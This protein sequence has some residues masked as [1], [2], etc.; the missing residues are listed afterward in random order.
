M[1]SYRYNSWGKL[2]SMTD[3]T[4]EKIG[5]KNP[6]R[7]REYCWDEET[8]LYYVSSRYYDPEVGR[9]ISADDVDVLEVQDDLYDKNLY[10]YCDN[11][12]INRVDEEG[13]VW[14]LAAV[15]SIGRMLGT[16]ALTISNVA[17]PIAVGIG[18]GIVVGVVIHKGLELHQSKAKARYKNEKDSKSAT[19]A[20][21]TKERAKYPP[22]LRKRYSTRKKAFD[23]AKRAGHKKR[24][25]KEKDKVSGK[26]FHPNVSSNQRITPKMPSSHNHYMYPGRF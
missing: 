13:D 9:F 14:E 17:L 3:T 1:V 22:A 15:G 20:K 26:H 18:I 11:N 10:A 23:A 21:E 12:P 8:G 25:K 24:P 16:A 4:T 5:E 7:Y 19:K 6:F 2:L